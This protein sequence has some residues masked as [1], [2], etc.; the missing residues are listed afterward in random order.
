MLNKLFSGISTSATHIRYHPGAKL[1]EVRSTLERVLLFLGAF[2]L[3]VV[4]V[5]AIVINVVEQHLHIAKVSFFLTHLYI[6]NILLK[7]LM[8]QSGK[9][10]SLK[11]WKHFKI[12]QTG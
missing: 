11:C 4:V 12:G 1:W 9:S 8:Q 5:L 6:K 2:L 3:M 10:T 7:T